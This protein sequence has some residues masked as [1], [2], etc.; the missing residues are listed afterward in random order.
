MH[1]DS[2][3]PR[4]PTPAPPS[5]SQVALILRFSSSLSASRDED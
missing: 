3:A 4:S 1:H 2:A 5:T